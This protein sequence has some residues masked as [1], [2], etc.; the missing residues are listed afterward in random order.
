M[1]I[2]TNNAHSEPGRP[3]A[4]GLAR[5]GES[6]APVVT[7]PDQLTTQEANERVLTRHH[8]FEFLDALRGIAACFVVFYH[9][10]PSIK[11]VVS[12]PQSFLAVDFFFALS[13]FVIAFSYE[14]RLQRGMSFRTFSLARITRL[15]PLYF[16]GL[17]AGLLAK[18]ARMHMVPGTRT[19]VGAI[20]LTTLLSL[21]MLPALLRNGV[22][23]DAFP[24]NPPSW[25]L[26]SEM[27]AN[28][29]YAVLAIR[30]WAGSLLIGA[31][32]VASM[33]YFFYYVRY[34]GGLLEAGSAASNYYAGLARVGFSFFVGVLIFRLR[35]FA[36]LRLKGIM[37]AVT[38]LSIVALLC[39]VLGT[40]VLSANPLLAFVAIIILF[41]AMVFFGAAVPMPERGK[42][43][44]LRLGEISYP[45]YVLHV[46]LLSPLFLLEHKLPMTPAVRIA[47][48]IYLALLVP[49]TW[50][51]ALYID[52]PIR[53]FLGHKTASLR[54][55]TA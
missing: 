34:C 21:F 49:L 43:L 33:A 4:G 41:P 3:T 2:A 45:L 22:T 25:S 12:F 15:Y 50:A 19:S 36:T 5:A 40:N 52:A 32:S 51:I 37:A 42:R 10:P 54:A 55:R 13:G 9:A 39:A 11:Q 27:A 16:L 38:A 14:D 18:L 48:F 53:R 20:A 23:A 35:S 24:M 7:R 6:Q 1:T 26:F 17:M 47:F 29:L 30:R 8:R 44:S 46:P 28:L 31:I